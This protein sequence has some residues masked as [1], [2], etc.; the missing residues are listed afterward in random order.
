MKPIEKSSFI[1]WAI[2]KM[3]DDILKFPS[4]RSYIKQK[5][6]NEDN[7]NRNFL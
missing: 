7:D 5:G 4:Q 1:F 2:F 3:N 6:R